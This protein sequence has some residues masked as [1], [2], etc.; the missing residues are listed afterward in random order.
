MFCV[1]CGKDLQGYEDSK[2]CPFCGGAVNGTSAGV[3]GGS[4]KSGNNNSI[5][6]SIPTSFQ[7]PSVNNPKRIVL[8]GLTAFSAL[9]IFFPFVN[10]FVSGFGY[11]TSGQ[12]SYTVMQLFKQVSNIEKTLFDY[13]I[14]LNLSTVR[15]MLFLIILAFII[16]IIVGLISLYNALLEKNYI[17]ADDCAVGTAISSA[18]GV[19]ILWI[20]TSMINSQIADAIGDAGDW[21]GIKA[22]VT[23]SPLVFIL[24]VAN[25]I[26]FVLAKTIP[27][28]SSE[29]KKMSVAGNKVCNRCGE[30]FMCG[31]KCP[32]CKSQDIRNE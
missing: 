3:S 5:N 6:I 1:N 16:S 19:A 21:F 7:I 27:V 10:F 4:K 25:V 14:D 18:A 15:F 2:F 29:T 28:D 13:G 23:L 8:I 12:T 24:L 26:T 31:D 32:S 22:S 17:A 20:G 30:R 11:S 9:G